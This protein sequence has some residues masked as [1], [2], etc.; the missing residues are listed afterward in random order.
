MQDLKG[1]IIPSLQAIWTDPG[2]RRKV[3]FLVA[4]AGEGNDR[5]WMVR[6]ALIGV[7]LSRS[8]FSISTV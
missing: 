5:G 8:I 2:S 6:L 4:L 7:S 1:L 3:A